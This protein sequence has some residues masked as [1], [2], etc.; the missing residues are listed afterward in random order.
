MCYH[1]Q[2][3]TELGIEF[4]KAVR[5]LV[6]NLPE[7]EAGSKKP[8]LFHNIRVGV[9]LYER[10]YSRDVVVAG[11]LHDTLEWSEASEEVLR[12][13]FGETVL[14]LIRAN[15]KDDSILDKEEKTRELI[16][17][18]VK[19]GE[20]AL[21][22]KTADILDSYRWYTEQ[23]NEKGLGYCERNTSAI[24]KYKPEAFTDPIF[25]ELEGWLKK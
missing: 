13:L 8:V 10:K 22:V 9:Y 15:T 7:T 25:K 1:N 11:L 3:N 5:F 2:M 20:E 17:R 12:E 18:C 24:L 14:R 16:T 4:E 19:E 23:N 6:A 21:I